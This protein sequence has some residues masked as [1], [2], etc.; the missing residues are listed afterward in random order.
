[1]T[2][3]A[4]AQLREYPLSRIQITSPLGR[5]GAAQ[6]MRCVTPDNQRRVLKQYND[7]TLSKLSADVIRDLVVWPEKLSPENARRIREM[8]AWPLATV[9]DNRRVVGVILPEAP[10]MFFYGTEKG[11][12]PR[13]FTR[14][15]VRK[16]VAER[17]GHQYFDFPQ[18]VARLG[19]LLTDLEFL[20]A[21][22]IVVGDLQ[23][24]NILTTGP[25]PA[26]GVVTVRNYFLD[27]DSFVVAGAAA[28]PQLDPVSWRPPWQP[29]QFSDAS[30]LFKLALMSIRCMAEDLAVTGIAFE[31][32][33]QIMPTRDRRILATLLSSP[34]P[35]IA[36]MDL[37]AMSRAWQSMVNRQGAMHRQTDSA[38]RDP[39][40]HQARDA[41]L[42][43]VTA[44]AKPQAQLPAPVSV[45]SVPTKPVPPP[46]KASNSS[47]AIVAIALTAAVIVFVLMLV[48]AL[49]QP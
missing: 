23:P 9:T 44:S 10:P 33:D 42:R 11:P 5:G 2:T 15:A 21:N 24:H 31:K 37:I 38:L 29:D 18:K 13:H 22:K 6:V 1:M 17:K 49:T 35:G 27:C 25:Q 34:E 14:V 43:R 45:P 39:W 26:N 8:C 30:D 4:A 46:A 16:D 3:P 12:E 28:M 40:T 7:E 48:L 47:R 32:F 19:G 36:A 20:H 41:H